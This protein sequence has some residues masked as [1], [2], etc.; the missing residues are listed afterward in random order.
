MH[1]AALMAPHPN[2]FHTFMKVSRK[3][4]SV[5]SWKR[6]IVSILL[7]C[8]LGSA[9]AA[10]F[11]WDADASTSGNNVDGTGLGG[12]G[13]WDLTTS[14]W[15]NGSSLSLWPNTSLDIAIFSAP[16][17]VLPTLSTVTLS[18]GIT[19]GQLSFLRSGFALTG[20]YFTLAGASPSLRAALGV[21][22]TIDNLILGSSGLTML[23][24]G[25]IRLIN[26]SSFYT[27]TT[28]IANGSIIITDQGALGSDSSAIVV[29]GF[30]PVIASTNLR[31]FGGGSLVLDGSG[32]GITIS[33]DLLLQGQGPIADR[34]GAL[35]ST[36]NNTLSGTVT[37]GAPYVATNLSTRIISADGTLSFTGTLNVLGTAATT[38]STLG[39]TNQAGAS[40][41]SVT[42]V[43]TGS[44]TLEGSGGGTL[45]LNPSDSSGFSGTIRVSGS[46][47][48]GQS[49]VRIDSPNVLG[50]RTAG[51]TSAVL[52]LNGGILA[53]LMDAPE[54]KV[55]NGSNA[56]VYFR[57][58]STIYADHTPNSS[59]K[60]QT[61]AFG[62][63]S[64][65]DGITLTFNSRNGYGMSF[66]TSPVNGGNGDT[67]M[68]N[69]LQGGAL[70]TFTGNFW[71]N[72]ENTGNRTITLSGNGNTLIN[73]NII[74]ASADFS[75]NLVKSGSGTL[76]ITGTASTLD[77]TVSI[78]GG[79]LAVSDWRAI[80]NM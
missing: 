15:W 42:G 43:L 12:T 73:G 8:Q 29:T 30:N 74:G 5:P 54:V 51:T 53:V 10:T 37:M 34:S 28:T 6:F 57:A 44:G 40:F 19:V 68:A 2:C 20:G 7:T 14:N 76:T 24:G 18:P 32:G 56:N 61:V 3:L 62:N 60:D 26:T 79:T 50:S 45:F 65:E 4:F 63:L 35:I 75:H 17:S 25:T 70:L 77:G 46:A 33:R 49:V 55:S 39:G 67:T 72:T 16:F 38:I 11:Y 23:G 31:G 22:A 41:Y 69:N 9:R 64:Y 71:S 36:G 80:N 47:A 59:V 66:T 13:S 52:D 21:T 27:G 78:S 48:S 58:A 1:S